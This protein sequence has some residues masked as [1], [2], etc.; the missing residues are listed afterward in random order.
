MRTA[1]T[2][3]R[4]G[5]PVGTLLG[6]ALTVLLTACSGAAPAAPSAPASGS[7]DASAPAQPSGPKRIV[8][9]VGA[10]LPSPHTTISSP[11]SGANEV[12]QLLTAGLTAENEH[13]QP[14][15]LLAEAVP[16]TDNGLWK[17][18]P[19]GRMETTWRMREGARWHD[20]TPVTSD[21]L[22]FTMQ[23]VRDPETAPF[24]SNLLQQ[25]IE[26]VEAPDART[27]TVTWKRP[28]I[29]ADRTFGMDRM[30]PRHLLE[31]A[32]LAD[33][34]GFANLPYWTTEFVSNGP[35]QLRE[36]QTGVH[37]NLEAFDGYPLG[38][39]KIDQIQVRFIADSNTMLAN[40]LSDAM[41]VLVGARHLAFDQALEVQTR[42]AGGSVVLGANGWSVMHPQMMY[43]NPATVQNV[44]YRRAMF[45]AIDRQAMADTL[46]GGLAPVAHS[47]YVPSDPMH[48]ATLSQVVRYDYDPARAAQLL[49]S[50]GFRKGADGTYLDAA[51]QRQISEVR[52]TSDIET[53]VKQMYAI[54]DYWNRLGI[55]T[56][57]VAIPPQRQQDREYRSTFC[58][59]EV[60]QGGHG[61][62]G[63]IAR[64]KAG[65]RTAE[66]DWRGAAP[67]NYSNYVNDEHDA[68]IARYLT[69]IPMDERTRIAG[70]I[71][72][73]LTD[74]VLMMPMYY[75]ARPTVVKNSLTGIVGRD[76]GTVATYN[77]T[78]WE[79]R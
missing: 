19:D 57:A 21:D 55:A 37:A 59:F 18:F 16:S 42:W 65:A 45:L 15:P 68:L 63:L 69:T 33:K 41:D 48:Q 1:R 58:C 52:T 34:A 51:G 8:I 36:W 17:V 62:N 5:Q 66:R 46:Q 7:T 11:L 53:T 77:V 3:T 76:A 29:Q 47:V 44:L 73:Q 64:Q 67:T 30:M 14:V 61:E 10:N 74:Q 27:V 32:Y 40:V 78:Q 72:H 54:Q 13:L 23:V 31:S 70:Q 28:F 24:Y 38:R 71:L 12:H 50:L 39:T 43:S 6:L 79:V 26:S 25:L 20:G 9:G 22:L 35:Y 60:L 49:E 4:P 56:E 75:I 2:F